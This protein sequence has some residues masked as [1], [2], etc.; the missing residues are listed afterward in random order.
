MP[1]YLFLDTNIY[2][3]YKPIQELKLHKKYGKDCILVIPRIILM[4]LNKHKDSHPNS[5]I[6]K[7]ARAICNNIHSWDNIGKVNDNIGFRFV[8]STSDPQ[9]YDLNPNYADDRFLADILD[10]NALPEDKILIAADLSMQLTAKH[11]GIIFEVLDESYKIPSD[12]DP[13]EEENLALKQ[14]IERLQNALPKLKVGLIASEGDEEVEPTPTFFFP[15]VRKLTEQELTDEE[16]EAKVAKLNLKKYSTEYHDDNKKMNFLTI[17]SIDIQ[18]YDTEIS[19]YPSRY[20][21]YLYD[22][23]AFRR[24]YKFNLKIAIINIGSAPAKDIDIR[25]YF[26]DGFELY[27]KDD[28]PKTPQQPSLPQKPVSIL[29]KNIMSS[30]EQLSGYKPFFSTPES[31]SLK[32][33]NSYELTN[34]FNYIKH[35]E[36]VLL[37]ELFLYFS[38]IE[39]IKPFQCT[40]KITVGNLPDAINGVIHFNFKEE[41]IT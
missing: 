16:I 38:N 31:Y 41:V 19:E 24:Q 35:N 10:F 29:Q 40:Y 11:L 30:M 25:C 9:K 14:Q 34:S 21:Q 23:R 7:K 32:R 2:L 8:I 5:K 12:K 28:S 33:T 27:L 39:S 6:K 15:H 1:K 17:S 4:E 3:H 22:L 26:P 36:K 13:L 18:K 20:R 37:P